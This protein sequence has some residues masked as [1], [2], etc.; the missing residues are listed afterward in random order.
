MWFPGRFLEFLPGWLVNAAR[1]FHSYE[2]ILAMG[3]LFTVPLLQHPP[4]P[5]GLSGGTR[6]IFSGNIPVHEIRSAT[7][8]W[9]KRLSLPRSSVRGPGPSKTALVISGFYLSV[10]FVI[11]MLVM[12][13][14]GARGAPLLLLARHG[15]RVGSR[16]PSS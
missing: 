11:L 16:G 2:A 10:G 12:T 13:T 3:F 5:E 1:I 4:A 8:G 7:P 14:G 6:F 15:Q 9:Y